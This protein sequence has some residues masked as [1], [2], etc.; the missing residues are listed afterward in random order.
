MSGM[1][2]SQ[3]GRQRLRNQPDSR[4]PPT[5]EKVVG[6]F[7]SPAQRLAQACS[8]VKK[9]WQLKVSTVPSWSGLLVGL[10]VDS[11]LSFHFHKE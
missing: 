6:A 5:L 9:A 10:P 11:G 8:S 7:S 4:C 3:S 2:L 1:A